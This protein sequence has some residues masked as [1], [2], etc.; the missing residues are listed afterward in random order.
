MPYEWIGGPSNTGDATANV[1]FGIAWNHDNNALHVLDNYG[2]N[3]AT[4]GLV[5]TRIEGFDGD[6]ILI[7]DMYDPFPGSFDTESDHIYGGNG[8]DQIYGDTSNAASYLITFNGGPLE[9]GIDP[10]FNARV[11][12]STDRLWG[13]AGNDSIWGGGGSDYIWGGTG[14]D[15]LDGGYGD[16]SIWGGLGK[17]V[18]VGGNGA[19]DFVFQSINETTR[20]ARDRISGFE[21]LLDDIDLR[22]IDANGTLAGN[23]V[24]KWIGKAAFTGV[25]GQLHYTLYN[26]AGVANDKTII[27]G[28]LNGDRR[29]DF[30]IELTGLVA[31]SAADFFL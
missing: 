17:D 26:P 16:D 4:S 11:D 22:G 10:Q 28:D 19:D 2:Q 25:R 3:V 14:N 9:V 5:G 8:N 30:Q 20:A 18:M 27:E 15:V 13:D 1:I 31:L 6:D 21:H 29:A 23:G 24:F 7:G 12:G